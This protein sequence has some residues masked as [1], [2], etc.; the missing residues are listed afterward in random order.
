MF[1]FLHHL[2]QV[3]GKAGVLLH[4]PGLLLTSSS[5]SAPRSFPPLLVPS[6]LFIYFNSY[7]SHLPS[8]LSSWIPSSQP[9]PPQSSFRSLDLVL[10]DQRREW[11]LWVVVEESSYGLCGRNLQNISWVPSFWVVVFLN[12]RLW[13]LISHREIH[14]L[15][16]VS[17]SVSKGWTKIGC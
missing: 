8:F 3:V 6:Y 4:K 9:L 14:S 13:K 16:I 5:V 7:T 1:L 11:I 10:V 12:Y 17:I 2:P 15:A